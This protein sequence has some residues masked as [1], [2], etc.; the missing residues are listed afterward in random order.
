MHQ[1]QIKSG[2]PTEILEFKFELKVF[3]DCE[4]VRE[5]SVFSKCFTKNPSQSFA[6]NE[7]I[8]PR[9]RFGLFAAN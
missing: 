3:G 6:S 5:D 4:K 2:I 9:Q 1:L 7:P 8:C